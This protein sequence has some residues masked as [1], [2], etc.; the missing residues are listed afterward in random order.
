MPE[1]TASWPMLSPEIVTRAEQQTAVVRV[2]GPVADLPAMIREAFQLTSR[3]IQESGA[4]FAGPPFARYRSVGEQIDAEVGF[5]FAGQVQATGRV[6]LASLPAG[7]AVV[8]TH[9]GP[10]EELGTAW[11]HVRGWLDEHGLTSTD[12]PWECYLTGPD[13]PGPPITEI[14]FPVQ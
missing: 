1:M 12:V 9:V 7:R 2:H 5:P 13:E 4:A 11:G 6:Y 10:Y 14:V 3:A 8:M